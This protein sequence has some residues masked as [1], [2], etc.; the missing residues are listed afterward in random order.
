M[1]DSRIAGLG[2]GNYWVLLCL[3]LVSIAAVVFS[4]APAVVVK[5]KVTLPPAYEL[6]AEQPLAD[7]STLTVPEQ[8]GER[9]HGAK[10]T[11]R[12]AGSMLLHLART[13]SLHPYT[14]ATLFGIVFLL[15]G[16]LVGY[17]ISDDRLVGLFL[18]LTF[19]GLYATSACFSVNWMPKPFDGIALGLLGLTMISLKKRSL[20]A[21]MSFLSCWA[22]ERAILSLF[23]IALILAA[24][25]K[26]ERKEKLSRLLIIVASIFLYLVSLALVSWTLGWH[27]LDMG[28]IGL[29]PRLACVFAPLAAWSCFEGAWIVIILAM[30]SMYEK[31]ENLWLCLLIG[32]VLLAVS[33]CVLVLDVSRAS[34]FAFPLIP[35]SCVLLKRAEISQRELRIVIAGAAVVS[36][37][38]PNFE[39]VEGVAVKCLLPLQSYFL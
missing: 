3:I 16:I 30:W 21:I 4:A 19:S 9:S 36:L 34:S 27:P 12:L 1:N 13:F 14:P 8:I 17:Q 32:S 7:T 35:L 33:S 23:F 26:W 22:D 2:E 38:A 25:P 28:M 24:W 18:G 6:K 37:L 39:I 10:L 11:P 31:R 20:L 5:R 29:Q 15:S